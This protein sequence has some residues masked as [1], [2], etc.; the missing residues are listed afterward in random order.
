MRE[1]NSVDYDKSIFITKNPE[2][3]LTEPGT[4]MLFDIK[5]YHLI[6]KD[7]LIRL[8]KRNKPE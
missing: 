1:P 4:A 6:F 7:E 2:F 8:Y 3:V 5:K